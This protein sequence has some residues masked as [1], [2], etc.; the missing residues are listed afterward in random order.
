[1]TLAEMVVSMGV[2]TI[3]LATAAAMLTSTLRG[4]AL[5]A[6]KTASQADA[7][8]AVER[9]SRDLRTAVL[10]PAGSGVAISVASPTAITFYSSRD[11]VKQNVYRISYSVDATSRCLRRVSTRLATAGSPAAPST[12]GC[13]VPGRVEPGTTLFTYLPTRTTLASAPTPLKPPSAGYTAPADGDALSTIRAVTITL[14][15]RASDRP[16]VAPSKAVQDVTLI[17]LK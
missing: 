15:L 5:A 16:A 3:V 1:M 11:G 4:N 17:N 6:G 8:L 9:L 7:R 14:S 10:D 13:V 2:V 12:T